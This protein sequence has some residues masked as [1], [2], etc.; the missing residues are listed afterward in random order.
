VYRTNQGWVS[1]L[2]TAALGG[3]DGNCYHFSL[4]R[5][6]EAT[7]FME[8]IA[9]ATNRTATADVFEARAGFVPSKDGYTL[10]IAMMGRIVNYNLSRIVG[11]LSSEMRLSD[12]P[13]EMVVGYGR[14][15][16][17]L[18][19][20]PSEWTGTEVSAMIEAVEGIA[21]VSDREG[22]KYIVPKDRYFRQHVDKWNSRPIRLDHAFEALN[23][24]VP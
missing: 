22:F 2:A 9:A 17:L 16:T 8:E 4:D 18:D 5:G 13:T 23:G 7:R 12:L 1:G 14:I 19:V 15:R 10:D 20:P 3:H 11:S 21:A 24:M 6:E